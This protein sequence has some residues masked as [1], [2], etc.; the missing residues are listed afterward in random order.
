MAFTAF[1]LVR[2]VHIIFSA[3][4]AGGAFFTAFILGPHMR[5]AGP[6]AGPFMATIMRRGGIAWYPLTVGAIALLAGGS[7]L[8]QGEYTSDSIGNGPFIVLMA[9]VALA[10]LA[11]LVGLFVMFP[12]ERKLKALVRSMPA[13]GPPAPDMQAQFQQL[14][15]KQGKTGVALAGMLAL[16]LL[17]MTLWRLF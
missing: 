5:A 10:V 2:A 12:T 7:T 15:M 8:G 16:A 9:G 14:G 11:Y 17:C 4:W 3:L 6:A 13:Q 1:A